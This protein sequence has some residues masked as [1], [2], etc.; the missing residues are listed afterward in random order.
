LTIKGQ[1]VTE[2]QFT[3]AKHQLFKL[4]KGCKCKCGQ[5]LVVNDKHITQPFCI[6]CGDLSYQWKLDVTPF[7]V[8]YVC[9]DN[10]WIRKNPRKLHGT[11]AALIERE[12]KIK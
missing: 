11:I 7:G 9:V 3:E 5:W 4:L 12:R 6:A 8:R 2:E 10:E 1:K